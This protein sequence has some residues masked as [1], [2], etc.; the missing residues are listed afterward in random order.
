MNDMQ[1]FVRTQSS[2][3]LRR[4]A[5]LAHDAA[6]LGTAEAIHDLR[7]GIRRLSECLR[8]FE[9]FFPK[10][11]AKKVRAHLKDVMKLAAEVRNRDIAVALLQKAEMTVEEGLEVERR[12]ARENLMDMLRMWNRHE[13]T[14][15]WRED[16]NV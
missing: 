15:K 4:L 10:G 11:R 5:F 3:L 6:Q 2:T 1:K 13:L 14:Q 9:D 7:V 16:L 8:E 12:K